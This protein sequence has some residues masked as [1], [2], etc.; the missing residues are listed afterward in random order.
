MGKI[1]Y[2]TVIACLNFYNV[3]MKADIFLNSF[4]SRT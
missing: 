2:N 3:Y 1:F 4:F